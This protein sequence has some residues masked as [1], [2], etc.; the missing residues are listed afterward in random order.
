MD[1]R[2]FLQTVSGAAAGAWLLVA[3]GSD[4]N[5]D[6]ATSPSGTSAG[7]A[8]GGTEKIVLV[9]NAWTAS[10]LDAEIAKQLI[11]QNFGNPV[12]ITSIDENTMYDGLSS[13]KLDAV[14]EVWPSGLSADEQKY[15]D[16]GSV[17]DV[18]KLGAVGRI[19]WYTPSYVLEQFPAL[20]TWEGLKDPAIAKEFASA[21]TADK[22]R[23][24][25][26]DPSYSQ[27]DEAIITNLALP[28]QVVYSGSEAATVAAVDGAVAAKKPILLYW[29]TPTATTAKY[30]LVEIELPAYTDE[31]WADAAKIACAYPED[32]L[33]KAASAKLKDKDPA[34]WAFLEKFS[35]SN[36]DQ[37]GLLPAVEIDKRDAAEVAAEWIAANEATWKAWV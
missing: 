6:G 22:G 32:V 9:K 19:G 37:L 11:E 3:C 7:G 16:N 12:E 26:T 15:Y 4:D 10:A 23:F 8:S 1:R 31:C 2:T 17:V 5:D 21:E 34:V 14:L 18:G 29:W 27:A 28:F 30:D 13:G 35:L 24:L 33:L 20:K 25:G 36:E